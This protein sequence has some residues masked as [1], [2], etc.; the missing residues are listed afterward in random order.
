VLQA[1]LRQ[2]FHLVHLK[3][4]VLNLM[5]AHLNLVVV[6]QVLLGLKAHLEMGV[7]DLDLLEPQGQ[8]ALLDHLALLAHLD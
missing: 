4:V 2:W 8:L 6:L 7:V 1:L 3:V 5:L